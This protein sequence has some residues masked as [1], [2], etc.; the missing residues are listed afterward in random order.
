MTFDNNIEITL[1]PVAD[2]GL[3]ADEYQPILGLIG[4]SPTL[5]E[6]GIFSATWNDR[7]SRRAPRSG[8]APSPPSDGRPWRWYPRLATVQAL[9]AR[10]DL[11]QRD[12]RIGPQ[13]WVVH[14]VL[15]ARVPDEPTVHGPGS[16]EASRRAQV[17]SSS[18]AYRGMSARRTLSLSAASETTSQ[19]RAQPR[20]VP[21]NL[22]IRFTP[23][24]DERR[25][26]KRLWVLSDRRLQAPS[27]GSGEGS[28]TNNGALRSPTS[29]ELIEERGRNDR[30]RP[31][32]FRPRPG[33]ASLAVALHW[34]KG[35]SRRQSAGRPCGEA[36]TGALMKNRTPVRRTRSGLPGRLGRSRHAVGGCTYSE[37]AAAIQPL[38]STL[39]KA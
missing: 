24:I 20:T 5:T 35:P 7:C 17:R 23:P 16:V 6:L 30:V 4:P 10:N 15:G 31:V 25:P 27:P 28:G 32:R 11:R 38:R 21:I 9:P 3:T 8:R 37:D 39:A 29:S 12:V 1:S 2:H 18:S 19:N 14:L 36:T 33:R 34:P 26:P 22:A 13:R